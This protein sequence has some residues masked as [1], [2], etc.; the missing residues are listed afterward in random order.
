MI[1]SAIVC[2]IFLIAPTIAASGQ[3]GAITLTLAVAYPVA[4]LMLFFAL[5]E[6]LF[7]S[8]KHDSSRPIILLA[9]SICLMIVTD[10]LFLSQSLK[11]KFVA[12]GVDTGW[13]A[14]YV[15]ME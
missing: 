9:A 10:F 2:W 4:D 5:I 11:G 7:R 12:G 13:I 8:F 1:A 6:L 3:A 15:L 14:S